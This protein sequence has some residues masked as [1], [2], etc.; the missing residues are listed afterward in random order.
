[1]ITLYK[2]G[3][4]FGLPDASPFCFKAEMLLK[5][6]GLE[7]ENDTKSFT[8]APKGKQPFL[9]DDGEIIADSTFI[10]MHIEKKYG[11]D[12][13]AGLSP[14]EAGVAWSVDKMLE[15]HLYWV[16]INDRWVNDENF[17]NGPRSFFDAA[18]ALVRPIIVKMVR[19][20]VI[21][22]TKAHGMGRHSNEEIHQ[23]A[24][25]AFDALAAILGD[26]KYFMGD[27]VCGVDATAYAWLATLSN[28]HFNTP[29]IAMID[30]HKNLADY[31]DRMKAQYFP[32]L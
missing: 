11:F 5:I 8:K 15:D 4:F 24:K 25:R 26:N 20:K 28:K 21:K 12:F 22:G 18:P 32:D 23:L 7:Y 6:A 16:L 31:R 10:R 29:V 17:N 3:P 13:D 30:G 19:S 1:M 27:T 9:K 2:F 14:Y